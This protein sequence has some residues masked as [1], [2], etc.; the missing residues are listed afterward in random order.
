VGNLPSGKEENRVVAKAECTKLASSLFGAPVRYVEVNT[1]SGAGVPTVFNTLMECVYGKPHSGAE[2]VKDPSP[3]NKAPEKSTTTVGSPSNDKDAEIRSLKAQQAALE[4]KLAAMTARFEAI[5]ARQRAEEKAA[6]TRFEAIE[7]KVSDVSLTQ[8][9]EELLLSQ[10]KKIGWNRGSS[11]PKA[12][13][14]KAPETETPP[15]VRP[16]TKLGRGQGVKQGLF[17]TSVP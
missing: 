12:S 13:P 7:A 16:T 5:E 11:P 10:L 3:E 14:Q 17:S 8:R 6:T 2:Q 4:A 15:K 9:I 1:R